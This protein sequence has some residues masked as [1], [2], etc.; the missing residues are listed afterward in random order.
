[1]ASN[2]KTLLEDCGANPLATLEN[3]KFCL[4]IF[5]KVF[6]VGVQH[7]LES[8]KLAIFVDERSFNEHSSQ[9]FAWVLWPALAI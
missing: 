8:D 6:S 1:M 5:F 2:I 4:V 3:I 9:G 7:C